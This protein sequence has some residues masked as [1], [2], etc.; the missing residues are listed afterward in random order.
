MTRHESPPSSLGTDSR[1]ARLWTTVAL[2]L[3]AVWIAIAL[4][5]TPRLPLL[6]VAVSVGAVGGTL[7]VKERSW[8]ARG[9]RQY[10]TGVLGVAA[11]V[12]VTVGVGHHLEAGLTMLA[13]LAG[14]SPWLLRWV[15]EGRTG[16]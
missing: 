7:F 4:L 15:A 5:Q 16:R 11:L 12:L 10:L 9:G 8:T 2:L 3:G 14:S 13:C 1:Y 6:A